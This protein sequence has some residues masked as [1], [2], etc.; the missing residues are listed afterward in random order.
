M[1][2]W[3]Q[4]LV[5][6]INLIGIW[7]AIWVYYSDNKKELNRWFTLM[8][9]F[10]LGW[11]DFAFLGTMFTEHALGFYR[12]NFGF[13]ALFILAFYNFYVLHFL[14]FVGRYKIFNQVVNILGIILA[15]LCF[16]TEYIIKEVRFEKWGPE[17]IFGGAESCLYI[18]AVAVSLIVLG[19]SSKTYLKRSRV[20]R[21][22]MHYFFIGIIF[23]I[24]FNLIFNIIFPLVFNTVEFASWGDYSAVILL[25]FTAYA[26]TKNNLLGVRALLTQVIIVI[27]TIILTLD[28]LFLSQ[29]WGLK[30][31]KLI[32][33]IAF[34]Y[35]SRE[36]I[37][38]VK[39]E[40]A[41]R[42]KLQK[43]N[44]RLEERNQD[45]GVLLEMGDRI[46]RGLDSVE[47]VQNAVNMV[48]Q[49]LSYLGYLMGVVLVINEDKNWF[50]FYAV[51]EASLVRRAE[52]DA[53]VELKTL[54]GTLEKI[55]EK[56]VA[57][58]GLHQEFM[59]ADL[60]D[61]TMHLWGKE[62]SHKFQ[63]ALG[64]KSFVGLP[65]TFLGD[66]MGV[67]IMASARS[68]GAIDKRNLGIV[69]TFAGTIASAMENAHLFE[70]TEE[71]YRKM[72]QL[73]QKLQTTNRQL[74]DL[75]SMKS[76]FLHLASHQLRTP[77]TSIRGMIDMWR[78]GDFDQLSVEKRREML[79]RIA[80]STDKLNKITNDMLSAFELEG[81]GR[82]QK[83][84]EVSV[85]NLLQ[86]AITILEPEYK[87]KNLYLKLKTVGK[88]LP[89][90]WADPTYLSQAFMNLID[91]A[92]NYTQSGG[93]EV[94]VGRHG[95]WV[96]IEVADTGIGINAADKKKLFQRFSRGLEAQ[97]NNA[98][99]SGLGLFIVKKIVEDHGGVITL[100]SKVGEG[101][102]FKIKLPIKH[103]K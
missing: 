67:L 5:A 95:A 37:R 49:K 20:E 86:E 25:V 59:T 3:E 1:S 35:Y 57:K 79:N 69:R 68:V 12:V 23:F 88:E 102:K 4:L 73:N 89:V 45:L 27:I 18:Y 42:N 71:Q 9:I 34:L 82:E 7:L 100:T 38:S 10:V 8:T 96:E 30:L 97:K 15:F 70:T 72:S 78:A 31:I 16:Q 17:I 76:D 53:S 77:L 60:T 85:T 56:A 19:I 63:A 22:Q 2:I 58:L 83:Y 51:T 36:L 39:R 52:K 11:V 6:I 98:Y 92:C 65:L 74:E 84:Q 55:G 26:I 54:N 81:G 50:Q 28:V 75:L 62:K 32:A 44:Q 24:L 87:K 101:S 93:A 29:G 94:T 14:N 91:N 66:D 33:L 103:T 61:F 46:G 48:P 41:S 64:A 43:S 99:G 80:D 40:Y 90:V 21:L 47:I 13:V